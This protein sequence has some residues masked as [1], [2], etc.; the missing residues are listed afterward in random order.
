MPTGATRTGGRAASAEPSSRP[1]V[2]RAALRRRAP[3]VGCPRWRTRPRERPDLLLDPEGGPR[4]GGAGRQRGR[5]LG[6]SRAGPSCCVTGSPAGPSAVPAT[7]GGRCAALLAGLLSLNITFTVFV[8]ALPTVQADFHT[9]FSVL[10]WASTGPLLAFGIAAPFFGKAGDLFG[11]RR[12]YL[13]GLGG[14]MVSA[15]AHGHRA[16]RRHAALRPRPRWRAGRGHRHRLDGPDP[17]ALRPR[18]AG[19]GPGLVVAGRR[20]RTGPRA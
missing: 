2:W 17:A 20:R 9:N 10:T 13:F 14:A 4:R 5:G 11:H 8:V 6:R 16:Q 19:Q 12:L 15:I 1:A 18:G 7:A 3:P